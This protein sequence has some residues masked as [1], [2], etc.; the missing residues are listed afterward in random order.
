MFTCSA[1]MAEDTTSL[2]QLFPRSSH[3]GRSVHSSCKKSHMAIHPYQEIQGI[4]EHSASCSP[5]DD[6][7]NKIQDY[8]QNTNTITNINF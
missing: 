8:F 5:D 7:L 2:T 4:Q 1:P 6:K 3:G